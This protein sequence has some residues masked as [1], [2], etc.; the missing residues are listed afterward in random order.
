MF[1][2][3]RKICETASGVFM[4]GLGVR[5]SLSSSD[6]VL[7]STGIDR[8]VAALSLAVCLHFE[9][10]HFLPVFVPGLDSFVSPT[11]AIS[12]SKEI[13]LCFCL[14]RKQWGMF[15]FTRKVEYI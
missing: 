2:D 8:E 13:C 3:D 10:C 14:Q 4:P 1:V 7:T 6:G 11:R 9:R 15:K 12:A 5:S